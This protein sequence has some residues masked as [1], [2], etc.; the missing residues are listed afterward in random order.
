VLLALILAVGSGAA[1]G[2]ALPPLASGIVAAFAG[3]AVYAVLW[4]V[5][6]ERTFR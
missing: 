1:A 4:R 3:A 2:A 5:A 6:T